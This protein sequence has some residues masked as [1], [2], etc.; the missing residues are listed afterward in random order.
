LPPGQNSKEEDKKK[1]EK[2]ENVEDEKSD[3]KRKTAELL[4]QL[5]LAKENLEKV[6]GEYQGSFINDVTQNWPPFVMIIRTVSFTD[7]DRC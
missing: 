3:W 6:E 2:L 5:S 7:L 4:S 1:K